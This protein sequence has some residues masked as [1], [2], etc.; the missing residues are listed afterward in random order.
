MWLKNVID[1]V[2]IFITFVE[3][4]LFTSKYN[5]RNYMFIGEMIKLMYEY[6]EQPLAAKCFKYSS[7]KYCKWVFLGAIFLV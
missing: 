1:Q 5:T 6:K 3:L 4:N 2:Y 7:T